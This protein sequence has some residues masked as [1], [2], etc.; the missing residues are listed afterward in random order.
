MLDLSS[1]GCRILVLWQSTQGRRVRA[2]QIMVMPCMTDDS[3][4]HVASV[5]PLS[6]LQAN[7]RGLGSQYTL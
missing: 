6:Q 1:N 5:L 2:H 3:A 7:C 4:C